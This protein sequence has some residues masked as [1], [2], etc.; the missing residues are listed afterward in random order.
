MGKFFLFIAIAIF[1]SY[2][3]SSTNLNT[4][5]NLKVNG[6]AFIKS[7]LEFLASDDLEGRNT[8]TH[9][10]EIASQYIASEFK[11]YG[12]LPYGDSTTYFQDFNVIVSS[13][14]E[15]STISV[16]G[17]NETADNELRLGDDFISQNAHAFDKNLFGKQFP[18]VFAG[19]GITADEYDYD[20]YTNIDP[21]GKVV[22]VLWGEPY[23]EDENF[24]NGLQQTKYSSPFTKI[25]SAMSKGA[26]GVLL[27]PNQQII[28]MWGMLQSMATGESVDYAGSDESGNKIIPAALITLN[29]AQKLF[30]GSGKIL[31]NIQNEV[32]AHEI[33]E[34]FD[35]SRQVKFNFTI[36][37]E[38]K[39]VRNV[40]GI[41]EGSDPVLKNEYVTIGAHYDH[42]GISGGQIYN[43]ADD[44]ASG[45]V[46][47]LEAARELLGLN[48]NKRSII[49]ILYTGEEK[50]LLGSN[51]FVNNFEKI[52]D[53]VANINLDMVGRKGIDSIYCI[54]SDR[55]SREL[56]DLLKQVNERTVK[57]TLD[58]SL[59]SGNYFYQSD[60]YSYVRKNI[61]VVFFNDNMLADLH[62][63]TDDYDKI[64]CEKI[65]KTA[66]LVK[67]L[68]LEIANL[69]HRLTFNEN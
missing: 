46:G 16:F 2:C 48:K 52:N 24:F 36:N 49:F 47:V 1:L 27:I 34:G 35:L 68:A 57:F 25:A 60:H 65:Y 32:E 6:V 8:A 45:T 30:E 29:A 14:D 44:N 37:S 5:D 28:S 59:S 31:S 66:E 12:I 23:S 19:F 56:D 40:V 11:K 62:K 15:K 10:E 13:F 42:V 38:K 61:P 69:D 64:N 18:L 50:G 39:T 63:P 4:A 9:S 55:T 43:G 41:I 22:I 3:S 53:V 7:N 58:Y 26:V 33:P 54:G 17:N 21:A 20:D 51:Y 67:E